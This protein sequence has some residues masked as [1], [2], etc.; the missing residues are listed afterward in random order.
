MTRQERTYY[1]YILTNRSGTLYTAV[2]SPRDGMVEYRWPA[3]TWAQWL[4]RFEEGRRDVVLPAT[5]AM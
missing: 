4:D 3:L 2:Y 1:F 5:T